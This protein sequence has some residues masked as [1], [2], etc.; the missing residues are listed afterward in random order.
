MKLQKKN[1]RLDLEFLRGFAVII[2]F[3]FHY[4]KQIFPYYYVGVDLFFLVSGYV[5]IKSILSKKTFNI[6]EFYLKRIKRIYPTML[7]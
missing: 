2:V 3:L 7:L 1:R 6:F 4:N 5:I